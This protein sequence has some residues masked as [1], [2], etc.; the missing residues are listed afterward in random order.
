[1]TMSKPPRIPTL[2]KP[3]TSWRAK[4]F[5]ALAVFV[6]LIPIILRLLGLIRP[7]SVPTGAMT[8]SVS[9]GD[10]IVMEGFTYLARKPHRG[11][12]MVFRTDNI[13]LIQADSIYIKRVAGEPG[14]RVR[15]SDG[16]LY[17][18]EAHVSLKNSSGEIRYVGLGYLATSND[19]VTV[20]D[21]SYFVLG[22]NSVNSAD[23]RYWGFVPAKNVMGRAS[24]CY[25]PPQR[26]G[27]IK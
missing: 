16:K 7:F 4:A 24:V 5:V 12:I 19:V 25:W 17:V 6:G 10:R 11:D 20:P 8:P 23:S 15:I 9:S 21:N 1:M 13:P 3:K 22:D 26:M 14:D 27:A 18:N 2:Q